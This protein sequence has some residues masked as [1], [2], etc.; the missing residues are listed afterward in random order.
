MGSNFPFLDIVLF[1]LLAGFLILRL[2]SVLGNK[3]GEEDDQDPF[4]HHR[5]QDMADN[6]NVIR[7]PSRADTAEPNGDFSI[8]EPTPLESG[9]TQI[10]IADPTFTPDGFV[11]GAQA[12]FEMIVKA[13]SDED[14][15]SLRPLLSD[16][17]F[18]NF[19]Q[20]IRDRQEAGED[21]DTELIS[22]PKVKLME[23]S[24]EDRVAFVTVEIT[25]EQVNVIKNTDGEVIEGDPNQ[26]NKIVDLWTFS[27]DT[28]SRDP[29]W[30]LV[31]TESPDEDDDG[32]TEEA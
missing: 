13:Y 1:A 31:A 30:L 19:T 3:N 21:L 32:E 9:L 18:S 2:R 25:S 17:V 14:E 12:A 15:A 28:T 11:G 8:D 24:M 29:N 10:S 5:D 20:A 16:E 7:M 27:R 26:I 22:Q 23:A 6:G 4:A